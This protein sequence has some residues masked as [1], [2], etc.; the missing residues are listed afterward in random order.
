VSRGLRIALITLG[1]ILFLAISGV[2][3]R[4]LSV[5]NAE[6]ENDL[7]LLRAQ[8]AGNVTGMLRRLHGCS[9]H[10]A[11]VTAVKTNAADPR[12][13]RSGA[14]KILQLTSPTAYSLTGTTGQTRLA[15]TV[16]GKLP[17]VQCVEVHRTGNF[18]T[19]IHIEL[20][21][22]SAPISNEGECSPHPKNEEEEL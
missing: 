14:V 12:L 16:I 10:P 13:R 5:E 7:A 9:E 15:W 20:V 2:L 18:L 4:F 6:R 21:G 19:G 17:I 22:L 3:A 8:T 1:V 11:C